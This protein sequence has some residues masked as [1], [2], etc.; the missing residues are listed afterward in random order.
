MPPPPPGSCPA[1]A[2]T[3][4]RPAHPTAARSDR[5]CSRRRR[6]TPSRSRRPA[7][8]SATVSVTK[9]LTITGAGINGSTTIA[10]SSGVSAFRSAPTASS[11]RTSRISGGRTVS[12]FPSRAARPRSRAS[13]SAVRPR[14]RRRHHG[15]RG[16]R[17]D[18]HRRRLRDRGR[19]RDQVGVE[20]PRDR[21]QRQRHVLHRKRQRHL[22]GE[23]RAA[24][25]L[26]NL[27]INRTLHQQYRHPIRSTL[28]E[29]RDS[30]IEDSTF[31][32]GLGPA[33]HPQVLCEQ[34]DAGLERRHPPQPVQR[35]HRQRARH[36]DDRHGPRNNGHRDRGQHDHEERRHLDGA[37]PR[38]SCGSIRPSRT[39]RS[40]S[41]TTPSPRPEPGAATASTA[42]SCAA[43]GR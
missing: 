40:T 33:R 31:T 42:S 30:T 21:P 7:R 11:S 1:T 20:Q 19:H 25:T 12:R 13:R 37:G 29:V 2:P 17:R 24:S 15:R 34:R 3:P 10:V 26:T 6:P 41:S 28:E 9:Q 14:W 36:R 23:R 5:R 38:P 18:H 8:P 32:G 27:A 22:R 43:T 35:L 4:A 39:A 16:Q